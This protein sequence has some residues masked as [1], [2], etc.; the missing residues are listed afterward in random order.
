[1]SV[2]F[3]W[4]PATVLRLFDDPKIGAVIEVR[5]EREAVEIRVTPGGRLR[6]DPV[7]RPA[8]LGP[9]N[10]EVIDAR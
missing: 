6:I 5:G 1:M 4:G 10:L 8:D 2:G 7:K 9:I 3:K